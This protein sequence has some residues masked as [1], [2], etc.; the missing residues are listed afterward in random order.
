MDNDAERDVAPGLLSNFAPADEV[1]TVHLRKGQELEIPMRRDDEDEVR[2]T[3]R[4]QRTWNEVRLLVV[5]EQ[6]DGDDPLDQ[7]ECVWSF[8]TDPV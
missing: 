6:F 1:T 5:D 4:V 3:V 8:L 7:T 2:F